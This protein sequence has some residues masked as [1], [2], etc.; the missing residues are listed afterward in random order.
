MSSA[1]HLLN[2]VIEEKMSKISEVLLGSVSPF[3]L[4]MGKLLGVVAVS[5]L[6]ALVYF[7]GGGSTR[8]SLPASADLIQPAL[9]GWFLVFLVCAVLM[10]GSMFHGDRLGVLGSEGRAEHDAAGDDAADAAYLASF[11]VLRAP[12]STLAVGALV[13]SDRDAVPDA[14]A[15]RDDARRRRSGRCC[16]RSAITARRRPALVVWAA[17][18]IFRVGLLM[19]GKAA[20]PA[21]AAALDSA[22]DR[23]D[24]RSTLDVIV[25]GAGPAGAGRRAHARRRRRRHAARRPGGVSAQQ[26]VRRR[27]QRARAARAFRGS[28]AALRGHRRAPHRAACISKVPTEPCCDLESREPCVL[29][30]RRV[31]FDARARAARR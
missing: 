27:H 21:R 3:Q 4:M 14:A 18:R 13:H 10:F 23:I 11:V 12:D 28:S 22:V 9:I 25:A 20:E 8:R 1:P 17:G 19:Q 6:L 29:L 15:P 16:C 30:I 5:V 24:G 31:E 2:A 7:C 26:A